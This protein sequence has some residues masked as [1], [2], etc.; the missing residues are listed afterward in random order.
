MMMTQKNYDYT[1][2]DEDDELNVK[3]RWRKLR[4]IVNMWYRPVQTKT[5]DFY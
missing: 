3:A 1:K 5:I 2:P 4:D